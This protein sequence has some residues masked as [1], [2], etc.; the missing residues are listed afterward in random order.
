MGG[1]TNS[2][3]ADI[4]GVMDASRV[5]TVMVLGSTVQVRG[6]SGTSSFPEADCRSIL[7]SDAT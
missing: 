4:T 3:S 2:G 1:N 5:C 6:T 7:D